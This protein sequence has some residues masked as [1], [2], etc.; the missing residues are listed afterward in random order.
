M[1]ETINTLIHRR[2]CRSYLDK[3]VPEE[4]IEQI[5]EAGLYAPTGRGSQGDA[6]IVITNKEIRDELEKQNAAVMGREGTSPFYGAPVVLLVIASGPLGVYDGSCLISNM[7]NAATSLG[8][9]S[10]WIHRAYEECQEGYGRQLLKEAGYGEE[11][12]GIGHVI[13]GY[14]AGEFPKPQARK[15]GRVAYFK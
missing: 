1:N 8:L 13:L 10:C 15:E 6:V 4:L 2:S 12:Y 5:V 9:G 14:P 7:M 3:E 11:Y